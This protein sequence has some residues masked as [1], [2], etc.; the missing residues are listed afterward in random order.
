MNSFLN[1][2]GQDLESH[3]IPVHA[4]VFT[5]LDSATGKRVSFTLDTESDLPC[6]F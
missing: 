1:K 2:M 6:G 3:A 5:F 4:N